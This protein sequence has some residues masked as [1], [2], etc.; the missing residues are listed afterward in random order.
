MPQAAGGAAVLVDP[1]D[2]ADIARGIREAIERRDELAQAG[3]V[4]AA[5]RNWDDVAREHMAVYEW[6]LNRT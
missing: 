4:R 3:R 6:S 1:F 2:V 5:L